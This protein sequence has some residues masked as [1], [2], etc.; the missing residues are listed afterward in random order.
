[1]LNRGQAVSLTQVSLSRLTALCR[2]LTLPEQARTITGDGR[3]SVVSAG[4][5]RG[6]V[7]PHCCQTGKPDVHHATPTAKVANSSSSSITTGAATG[8]GGAFTLGLGAGRRK[9]SKSLNLYC[10]SI[11]LIRISMFVS[12]SP[13]SGQTN[14]KA[15][16]ASPERRPVRPMRWT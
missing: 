16:P 8:G 9:D 5:L 14:V 1:Q 11:L 15:N 3:T 13:S 4:I 7:V 12:C 2:R 6:L 10:G